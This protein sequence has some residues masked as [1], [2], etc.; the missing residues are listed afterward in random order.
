MVR[1]S[2]DTIREHVEEVL[3]RADRVVGAV[4]LFG[5]QARDDATAESDI[6][7]LIVD[8][9]FEDI[10][11]YRRGHWF[12]SEWDYTGVGPL[13]LVCLT[14]TEYTDRLDETAAGAGQE[15]DEERVLLH[16]DEESATHD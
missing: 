12:K 5:S 2:T 14:P 10:P 7:I 13:E 9:S 8:E 3:E 15:V 6:D 16:S 1:R 11:P 4:Y